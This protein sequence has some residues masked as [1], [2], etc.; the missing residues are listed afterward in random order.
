MFIIPNTYY[1]T[2]APTRILSPQHFTQQ[3]QDH[4]PHAEGTG[5]MT[6]SMTIVLF[7]D[8]RKFTKTVKLDPKLNIAMTNTAPGIK[9]YRVK[10]TMIYL[11]NHLTQFKLSIIQK[12]VVAQII[13]PKQS[14]K[15]YS[16]LTMMQHLQENSLWNYRI[17]YQ[18]IENQ[19]QLMLKTN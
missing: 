7:W 15:T 11:S 12:Q 16:K 4:K 2:A 1:I 13:P 17:Q 18:M 10:M 9:Q 8:Q 14:Q 6:T 19:P 3:M 5:C